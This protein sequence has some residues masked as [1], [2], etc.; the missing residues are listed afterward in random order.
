M[1]PIKFREHTAE[2][3]SALSDLWAQAF[4]EG[5]QIQE[6]DLIDEG[7]KVYVG[8]SSGEIVCCF[9]VWDMGLTLNGTTVSAGGLASVAVSPEVRHGGVGGQMLRWSLNKMRENGNLISCLYAFRE[10]YYRKFGFECCGSLIRIECPNHRMPR[11]VAE[12]PARMV[13]PHDW[14]E[15][16]AC[17]EKFALRYNGMNIRSEARWE[18]TLGIRD[19]RAFIYAVGEPIEGFVFMNQISKVHE[20]QKAEICWTTPESY[21]GAISI[22]SGIGINRKSMQWY[23]PGDSP[24]LQ[25]YADA[26]VVFNNLLPAMYRVLDVKKLL[27]SQKPTESGKFVIRIQDNDIPDNCGPFK[28][29]FGEQVSVTAT[30][31]TG[32]EMDVRHFAQA[33]LGEPNLLELHRNGFVTGADDQIEIAAKLFPNR[34]VFLADFF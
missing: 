13:K 17:Y 12:Q 11:F 22:L 9:K 5:K 16:Q 33:I 14:R 28:V 34:R 10:S 27:E 31:E 25:S 30:T 15:L 19:D 3:R 26:D 24:F 29:E 2:N 20:D 7:G 18:R 1:P 32:I 21:R 4:R 8:E 6:S 23:E